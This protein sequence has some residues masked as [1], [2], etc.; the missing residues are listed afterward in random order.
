MRLSGGYEGD[1]GAR[2][3]RIKDL[4]IKST[5][6]GTPTF[7]E[8][9]PALD[10]AETLAMK[11]AIDQTG[12]FFQ[13]GFMRRFD[14]GYAAAKKRIH[15]GAIGRPVLFKSTSRDPYRTSLEYADPRSSGGSRR[16]TVRRDGSAGRKSRR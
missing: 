5:Q 4:S 10:V 6:A 1:G 16:P 3:A 13:M 12:V 9:P 15:E 11:E 2:R 7:C 14:A 8:K